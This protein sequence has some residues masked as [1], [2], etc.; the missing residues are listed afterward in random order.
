MYELRYQSTLPV[1]HCRLTLPGT[2]FNTDIILSQ[3]WA[4]DVCHLKPQLLYCSYVYPIKLI[5][6]YQMGS[7]QY[8]LFSIVVH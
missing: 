5:T 2:T 3:F 6:A 8:H 1:F 7:K 4:S